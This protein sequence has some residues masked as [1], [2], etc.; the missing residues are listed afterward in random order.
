MVTR[1]GFASIFFR[2]GLACFWGGLEFSSGQS[3]SR[4]DRLCI[5]VQGPEQWRGFVKSL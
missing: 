4:R 2:R 5:H 1:K 3:Q